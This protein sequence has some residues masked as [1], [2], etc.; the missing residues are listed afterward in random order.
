MRKTFLASLVVLVSS[1]LLACGSPEPEAPAATDEAPAAAPSPV[2]AGDTANTV[3]ADLPP[4]PAP[5]LVASEASVREQLEAQQVQLAEVLANADTDATA[6]AAA[7]G[8]L[9]LLYI[10]YDFLEAAGVAISNARALEPESFRW[11]YLGGYLEQLQGRLGPGVELLE[12]ALELEPNFLPAILRLARA[13]LELG[14]TAAAR[15]LFE[16]ALELEPASAAAFEGLG[17]LASATGDAQGAVDFFTRALEADPEATSLHYAL[18]Q[19]YRDAGDLEQARYHL[20]RRG[21]LPVRIP[22]P[23][24]NPLANLAQ[25]AQFFMMRGA[26][27]LE[28]EDFQAAAAAYERALVE[29]PTDF[30]AYRGLA[31]AVEKLGDLDGAI[32]HLHAALEQ[33]TQ[34]D[35]AEEKVERTEIH[36]ILGGLLAL[37]LKDAEAV[38]QFRR[39]LELDPDRGDVRRKLANALA[40]TGRFEDALPHYAALLATYPE[41][42]AEL[43]V[44]RAT[45]L[46]N[47]ERPEEAI[48]AFERAVAAE[49]ENAQTRL[50]YAEALEFLERSDAAAKQ[51][52]AAAR[53]AGDGEDRARLLAE[54]ARRLKTQGRFDEALAQLE[55]VVRLEPEWSAARYELAS[56]YGHLGRYDD[57]LGAFR[58][59]IEAEPR[60]AAARRGEIVVLLLVGRHDEAKTRLQEA[61][62]EFPQAA[63]LAHTQARLLASTPKIRVRDGR[64]ALEIALRLLQIKKDDLRVRETVAMALAE[65]GRFPEAVEMQRTVVAAAERRGDFHLLTD[66]REK[67][68]TFE[69]G[70]VWTAASGEEIVAVTL[71]AG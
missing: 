21:N 68:E 10:V 29:D 11:I 71:G 63:D 31:Y 38:E 36:R 42:T 20:E 30:K 37:D 23:L 2:I 4:V 62:R 50:R 7:Y 43:E 33:G 67:L 46:V 26:E 40:R 35:P 13:K 1:L 51:W 12:R 16:R 24:L 58:R 65:S 49:P 3:A 54:D 61:L 9:G 59:V 69:R 14:E 18:G 41:H 17:Q 8:D 47:L 55:E 19:A 60:H 15:T 34:D 45:A 66:V 48:A 64:L 32:R 56:L 39:S 5:D 57:A 22:D 53:L 70:Q 28:D 6:R 52:E 27:A 25:G 44:Q